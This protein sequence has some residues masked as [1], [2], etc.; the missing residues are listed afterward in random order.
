MPATTA[1]ALCEPPPTCSLFNPASLL[2]RQSNIHADGFRSLAEG[3]AL[4]Y[5]VDTNDQV[6]PARRRETTL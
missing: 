2:P 5:D 1:A 3:E 6:P 4:T